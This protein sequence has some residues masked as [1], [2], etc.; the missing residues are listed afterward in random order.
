MSF[1]EYTPGDKF[2]GVIGKT[3]DD[4][5]EAWPVPK[6]ARD[7]APNVL[8]YVIDVSGEAIKD[9]EAETRRGM[10]KQ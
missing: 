4:S 5:E 2:P 9:A 3:I 7:S 1:K 10:S 8:F 6:Q